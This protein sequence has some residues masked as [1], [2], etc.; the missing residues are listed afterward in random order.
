M[1][2][3]ANPVPARANDMHDGLKDPD[4]HRVLVT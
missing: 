2:L 4:S 3:I 1:M